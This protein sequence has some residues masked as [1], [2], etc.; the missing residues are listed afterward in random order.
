[1]APMTMDH[2]CHVASAMGALTV[3]VQHLGSLGLTQTPD[4]CVFTLPC[5]EYLGPE[6]KQILYAH[7]K[8]GGSLI[9]LD[10]EASEDSHILAHEIGH[11]AVYLTGKDRDFRKPAPKLA[12]LGKRCGF[13]CDSLESN[14]ELM[15]ECVAQKILSH[16][17]Y[18]QLDTF[19]EEAFQKVPP[20]GRTR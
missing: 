16:P 3:S 17:L 20:L 7:V 18:P 2:L 5:Y 8:N 9:F 15:A 19:C 1:M 10:R 11:V 12:R 4:W 6:E 13:D 14:D